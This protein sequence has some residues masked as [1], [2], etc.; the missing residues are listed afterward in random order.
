[1]RV[2]VFDPGDHNG[3]CLME[4]N[5]IELVVSGELPDWHGVLELIEEYKPS[6]IVFESFQLY[7]WKAQSLSWNTFLPVEVIGVIKYL[8]EERGIPCISQ[9]PAE[10]KFFTD[11][12]LKE[13][14][15]WEKSKHA[16]D[17]V[18]HGMLFVRYK[19]PDLLVKGK[20]HPKKY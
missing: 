19:L 3:W 17:A 1:M 5:P 4:S 10:R 18:R 6:I 14:G 20:I 7:A 15:M 2:L 9:G 12:K 13:L 16:R 11:E 8:A